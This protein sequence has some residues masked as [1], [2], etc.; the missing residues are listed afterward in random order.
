MP[1]TRR[2][3]LAVMFTDI[4]GYSAMV[5]RDERR[6][7]AL[8]EFQRRAVREQVFR[9]EGRV[10][11][12]IGDGHLVTFGNARAAIE[13][14]VALQRALQLRNAEPGAEPLRLRIGIHAGDVE[15]SRRRVF[16]DGVNV[17]ARLEALAPHGGVAVSDDAVSQLHGPLRACFTSAGPQPL[18][19]I[20]EPREV[21]TLGEP[22]LEAAAAHLAPPRRWRAWARRYRA[23]AAAAAVLLALAAIGYRLQPWLPPAVD[24]ASIAVLP[25]QNLST[26]PGSEEF[27]AGLHDSLLTEVSGLP[28][29]KV[30]S[31]TSVLRYAH[32]P[33]AIPEIGRQLNVAYVLEGSVQRTPQRVRINVQLIRARTDHHVWARTYDRDAADLFE[34][35]GQIAR[36][37]ARHTQGRVLLE[38]LPARQRPTR[39]VEAYDLYLRAIALEDNDP[40]LGRE[41]PVRQIGLLEQ[42]AARDPDF[43][44]AYAAL[45]RYNVWGANWASYHDPARRPAYLQ[46]AERASAEAL[47]LAPA[48]PESLLAAGLVGYWRGDDLPAVQRSLE[49]ALAARPQYPLALFW[50]ASLRDSLGETARSAELL[51]LLSALD[52]YNERVY[53]LIG[54]Q[55]LDRRDYAGLERTYERWRAIS[56]SPVFV[57]YW[58]SEL[59][60]LRSGDLRPRREFLKRKSFPGLTDNDLDSARWRLA[61]YEG[62]PAEAAR[63]AR[64]RS[65]AVARGES[66]DYDWALRACDA[67][68]AAGEQD[69][70]KACFVAVNGTLKKAHAAAPDDALLLMLLGRAE[71]GLGLQT[72]ALRHLEAAVQ[73]TAPKAPGRRRPLHYEA[74]LAWAQALGRF[75][76]EEQALDRLAWLL[77]EPSALSPHQ[78]RLDPAWNPLKQNPRFAELLGG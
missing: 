21:F 57:E 7:Q 74:T 16:G 78:V 10:V 34:V 54:Q 43:A 9:H 30:I 2:Q 77:A 11:E 25:L 71:A 32:Q 60:F 35:Q 72:E 41:A 64:P 48:L 38:S 51:E 24:D 26:E 44:L 18:K 39:D 47:R 70:A 8:L 3:L 45:A 27:V 52:P 73:L 37:I 46:A 5:N 56:S 76:R 40:S 20:A 6:A 65:D 14:A 1:A 55:Q 50:L 53:T 63:I 58:A 15:R 68:Q 69:E 12:T 66:S 67:L 62:R 22:A 42:A 36:E 19:N 28:E 61:M 75:G 13:C 23:A 4:V 17:A 33:P 31:R 49:Q 59:P 29:L